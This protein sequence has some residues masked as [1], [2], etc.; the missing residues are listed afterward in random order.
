MHIN[1]PK[2]LIMSLY[3]LYAFYLRRLIIVS[4][5]L[6]SPVIFAD[7]DPEPA[8]I[9]L[10]IEERRLLQLRHYSATLDP[11]EIIEQGRYGIDREDA[12]VLLLHRAL[13]L[14]GC[15]GPYRYVRMK[16]HDHARTSL[17]IEKAHA[18]VSDTAWWPNGDDMSGRY[19][20]QSSAITESLEV[21]IYS[22]KAGA[23]M[24][25]DKLVDF[26]TLTAVVSPLWIDDIKLLKSLNLQHIYYQNHWSSIVKMIKG[27]RSNFMLA[28]FQST[29]S[30]ALE[31]GNIKL[32]PV[33]G[34][35]LNM[36]RQRRWLFS[37]KNAAGGRAWNCVERGIIQLKTAGEIDAAYRSAG[38][39]NAKVK[40]WKL[41][42]PQG[43]R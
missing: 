15:P 5:V 36:P 32:Y 2:P 9:S 26:K 28:P 43:G 17:L 39:I 35:K 25:I 27:G 30:M 13:S 38:V 31:R 7:S 20:R 40:D 22:S 34:I 24:K 33:A 11:A 37:L 12:E 23:Q 29:A 41:L 18:S 21:G 42:S 14:G 1:S 3:R 4:L 6:F 8:Q 10:L 16:S 19:L